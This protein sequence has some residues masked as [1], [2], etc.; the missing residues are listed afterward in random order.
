MAHTD[1]A[2]NR[3]IRGAA[4]FDRS[5]ELDLTMY[6]RMFSDGADWNYPRRLRAH[7]RHHLLRRRTSPFT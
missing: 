3:L 1:D 6:S 5:L 7:P 2:I 4:A